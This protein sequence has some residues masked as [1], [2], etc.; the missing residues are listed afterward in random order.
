V[1]RILRREFDAIARDR[2]SGATELAL[3]AVKG[4]E[5]WIGRHAHPGEQDI[6][7]IARALLRAQPSLAPLLRLANDVA[8][9]ADADAPVKELQRV[10]RDFGDLLRTASRKVARRFSQQLAISRPR[11]VAT[12][13]YSS[14]VIAALIASRAKLACVICSESRPR[15]EGRATAEKLTRAGIAVKFFTDAGLMNVVDSARM[16]VLGADALLGRAFVNKIGSSALLAQAHSLRV[17][18]LVLADSSKF[19]PEPLAAA[20]LRLRLGEASELWRKPPELV[21]AE[22]P[23]FEYVRLSPGVCVMT[24]RGPMTQEQVRTAM[25]NIQIS[26]Q[27]WTLTD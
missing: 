24:E 22:N 10:A 6:L 8:L 7:A 25:K 21:A 12:Y 14:T 16:V 5:L 13:S 11:V 9:A 1:D 17:P 18:V 3:R 19:C 27:L 20:A 26:P 4:L 23:Y 2:N 15:C